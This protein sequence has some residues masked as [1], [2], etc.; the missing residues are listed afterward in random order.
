MFSTPSI[1]PVFKVRL[2]KFCK[3]LLWDKMNFCN[4]ENPDQIDND[5]TMT[6]SCSVEHEK[7]LKTIYFKIAAASPSFIQSY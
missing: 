4:K 3:E 6:S 5:V 1:T 2:L 7:V